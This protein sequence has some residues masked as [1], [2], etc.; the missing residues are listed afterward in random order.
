M[1]IPYLPPP[2]AVVTVDIV[3]VNHFYNDEGRPVWCQAI[4]W[5]WEP[6]DSEYHARDWVFVDQKPFA[7]VKRRPDGGAVVYVPSE[8]PGGQVVR[9]IRGRLYRES[10]TQF[11]RE[12][13]DRY[14]SPWWPRWSL[15]RE[16]ARP[17]ANGDLFDD[18]GREGGR[19]GGREA[20]GGR[21]NDP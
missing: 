4:F 10:W 2:A 7:D 19:D 13:A 1:A 18:T 6:V 15:W 9:E 14:R 5:E 11:D 20:V 16:R 12:A 3:E 17:L 21:G 8:V